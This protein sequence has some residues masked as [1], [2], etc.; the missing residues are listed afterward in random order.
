LTAAHCTLGLPVTVLGRVPK[1]ILRAVD[2]AGA[3]PDDLAL[4]LYEPKPSDPEPL[5]LAEKGNFRV[6]TCGRIAGFGAE[7]PTSERG[8]GSKRV[9]ENCLSSADE[10]L[11]IVSCDRDGD[12]RSNIAPGDS[13][14]P[15]LVNG[16]LLGVATGL[17]HSGQCWQG[18][19]V[20]LTS[21]TSRVFLKERISEN[22]VDKLSGT[23]QAAS[24]GL[25]LEP[26]NR[27]IHAVEGQ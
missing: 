17:I 25:S 5:L 16:K 27:F 24:V 22:P 4:I 7:D 18:W 15:F 9:G 13:G 10:L 3:G 8:I 23:P 26:I 11:L 14:G 2:T 1:T 12:L 20:N 6:G 19:F 21:E